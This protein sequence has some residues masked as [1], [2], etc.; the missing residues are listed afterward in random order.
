MADDRF[1]DGF[2]PVST[3]PVGVMEN[4]MTVAR[5]TTE[6]LEQIYPGC[7]DGQGMSED[8]EF[9]TM[10]AGIGVVCLARH[11]AK[12]M[13]NGMGLEG[14]RPEY[15]EVLSYCPGEPTYWSQ[16]S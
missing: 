2:V 7:L 11:P 8:T 3:I 14:V 9:Y 4:I 15:W 5:V 1:K 6:E 10:L 12:V 13:E 16:V